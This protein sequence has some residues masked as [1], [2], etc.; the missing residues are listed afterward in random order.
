[1]YELTTSINNQVL[2]RSECAGV[3]TM[4]MKFLLQLHPGQKGPHSGRR[5]KTPLPLALIAPGRAH[6]GLSAQEGLS[7]TPAFKT[8]HDMGDNSDGQKLFPT[9]SG[10]LPPVDISRCHVNVVSASPGHSP[11]G[12]W[13]Y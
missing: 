7:D 11:G 6:L 4:S 3:R 2:N 5:S 8:C 9:S 1:M 13:E 12:C 10:N